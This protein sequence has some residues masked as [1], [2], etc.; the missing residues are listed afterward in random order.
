MSGRSPRRSTGAGPRALMMRHAAERGSGPAPHNRSRSP[1]LSRSPPPVRGGAGPSD[2]DGDWV[3]SWL[4]RALKKGYAKYAAE[5]RQAFELVG[6]EDEDDIV[7]IDDDGFNQVTEFL[8]EIISAKPVHIAKLRRALCEAG[9]YALTR[10]AS[11]GVPQATLVE[12]PIA[13][14]VAVQ[15]GIAGPSDAAPSLQEREQMVSQDSQT[16]HQEDELQR[17]RA[18]IIRMQAAARG[19][20]ARR[21]SHEIRQHAQERARRLEMLVA[22]FELLRR[23]EELPRSPQAK[24]LTSILEAL[25]RLVSETEDH[26]L[27]SVCKKFRRS[28]SVERLCRLMAMP[29]HQTPRNHEMALILLGNMSSDLA[30]PDY[31]T[32][33]LIREIDGVKSVLQQLE[34]GD[35]FVLLNACGAAMNLITTSEDAELLHSLGL[36]PRIMHLAAGGGPKGFAGAEQLQQFASNCLLNLQLIASHEGVSRM[37]ASAVRTSAAVPIQAA[38]RGFIGRRR[39]EQKR[40]ALLQLELPELTQPESEAATPDINET[41]GLEETDVPSSLNSLLRSANKHS[42]RKQKAQKKPKSPSMSKR[43]VFEDE[44]DRA[45]DME[46]AQFTLVDV[47][48]RASTPRSSKKRGSILP[49]IFGRS[50]APVEAIQPKPRVADIHTQTSPLLPIVNSPSPDAM[51]KIEAGQEFNGKDQ[52]SSTTNDAEAAAREVLDAAEREA[53]V[54]RAEAIAAAE[55]AANERAQADADRVSAQKVAAE[56]AERIAQI[57]RKS[58]DMA[59]RVEKEGEEVKAASEAQKRE[60]ERMIAEAEARI[61]QIEKDAAK[62]I[63]EAKK[64]AIAERDEALREIREKS[65]EAGNAA[66]DAAMRAAMARQAEEQVAQEAELMMQEM[67]AAAAREAE[68]VN[69]AAET[70]EK[71]AMEKMQ[72]ALKAKESAEMK[73]ADVVK[74]A[75]ADAKKKENRLQALAAA[76]AAEAAAAKEEAA[77]AKAKAAAETQA[78][79][80]RLAQAEKEAVEKVR[81]ATAHAEAEQARAESVRIAAEQSAKEAA[82]R[83]ASLKNATEEALKK[84]AAKVESDRGKAKAVREAA[85]RKMAEAEA[86]IAEVEQAS[87]EAI[88]VATEQADARRASAEAAQ[89]EAE[90]Q[91]AE[92]ARRLVDAER[93]AAESAR[94]AVEQAEMAAAKAT[95]AVAEQTARAVKAELAARAAEER[96]KMA[97]QEADMKAQKANEREAAALAE[98]D[99]R[100]QLAHQAA[101]AAA[102][103]AIERAERAEKLARA[104]EEREANQVDAERAITES[105]RTVAEQSAIAE[106]RELEA[107]IAAEQAAADA[108]KA[109]EEAHAQI[110]ASEQAT[111]DA[112]KKAEEE[113]ERAERALRS[114]RAAVFEVARLQARQDKEEEKEL[115]MNEAEPLAFHA[116]PSFTPRGTSAS[117]HDRSLPKK[118]HNRGLHIGAT[119][120]RSARSSREAR[121]ARSSNETRSARSSY[122]GMPE[123]PRKPKTSAQKAAGN[124]PRAKRFT[125]ARGRAVSLDNEPTMQT[126][127]YSAYKVPTPV[128][129]IAA[130]FESPMHQH[131]RPRRPRSASRAATPLTQTLTGVA[132]DHE[133]IQM[134]FWRYHPLLQES[135]TPQVKKDLRVQVNAHV[136]LRF[137]DWKRKRNYLNLM[138]TVEHLPHDPKY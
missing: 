31:E 34:S 27:A 35:P 130:A 86:R 23:A 32:R 131:E 65:V 122:E 61:A 120:S 72:A 138:R 95:E 91:A 52:R 111:A 17:A 37:Y 97:A 94:V 88:R 104:A 84:A 67:E 45:N 41:A 77:A 71:A 78:A 8:V 46:V 108:A 92:A 57:E 132:E 93:A 53:E 117:R 116:S 48:G 69:A 4:E 36:M 66:S 107:R 126:A 5:Y 43:L 49:R 87:Q 63:R 79:A 22:N 83:S 70:A 68:A 28:G 124:T 64:Q 16:D 106:S 47:D 42:A 7:D 90:R 75:Q 15:G 115:M 118:T 40:A 33:Q 136:T 2:E 11:A 135:M 60:A 12:P 73:L 10:P 100:I 20:G 76:A 39:V 129:P 128:P 101:K 81:I 74:S 80:D 62:A 1:S 103:E 125:S 123:K 133:S 9:A 44:E 59:R 102:A 109:L 89:A 6:V 18:A 96:A 114:E 25:A 50:D 51:S 121:S 58:A 54:M 82:D 105:A 98:A 99:R 113:A 38:I 134:V 30:D 26:D 85:Q 55:K 56:A 112:L 29:T 137:D 110:R 24:D 19:F 21:V 119:V 3:A 14:G 13:T 127:T